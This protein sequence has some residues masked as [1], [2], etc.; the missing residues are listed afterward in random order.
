MSLKPASAISVHPMPPVHPLVLSHRLISHWGMW[1]FFVVI[2]IGAPTALHFGWTDITSVNKLGRY[3]AIALVALGLDLVW[4]YAGILSLCQMLFFTF[5]GYCI[6]MHICM[7]GPLTQGVPQAL[8]VV[9]SNVN[10]PVLPWFW[11]PFDSATFSLFAVLVIPGLVAFLFGWLA[12]R[13]RVRGVYFS[14]I[15]Q[16]LTYIAVNIFYLNE[17]KLCGTNGLTNLE[18]L[19]GFNI[20]APTVKVG[21]FMTTVVVLAGAY[22]AARWLISTRTGRVLIAVRDSEMRLRFAGYQPV[23]YKTFIF[24]VG[25]LLGAIGGALYVPQN[26]IITPAKMLPIESILIVVMVA[27]GGRGTLSGSI[28]GSLVVSYLYSWLT[29]KAPAVWPFF[30]GGLFI[31]VTIGFPRGLVGA[32]RSLGAWLHRTTTP[33]KSTT[34]GLPVKSEAPS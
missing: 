1:V 34:P 6:G 7:H 19:L 5:G 10:G 23:A 9:S 12:F 31:A 29:S 2:L 33:P 26:G 4:G 32:W 8:A 21:L 18:S 24:T 15:T 17:L 20:R 16:A 22:A 30:L 11:K 14:I 25:A 3:L 13:S 27:L 28:I